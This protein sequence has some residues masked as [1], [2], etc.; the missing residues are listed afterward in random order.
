MFAKIF[1]NKIT[2]IIAAV[3][4]IGVATVGGYLAL[5]PQAENFSTVQAAV[6]DVQGSVT[7]SGSIDSD[8]DVSLSFQDSGTVA[9]VGVAVGDQVYKGETLAS[10]DNSDLEAQLQ[11]AKA[12]VQ[13]AQAN[14]ESLQNGAT[15]QTLA[16]YDQGTVTATAALSTTI[17]D[18]YL[19]S[20][21]AILN[22]TDTLF[23]NGTSPNPTIIIPV[24][25]SSLGLSI[26]SQR[27]DIGLRLAAWKSD[28]A[29]ASSSASLVVESSGD[30]SV[31][32]SFLD[33]LTTEVNRLTTSNSGLT[34]SQ[35]SADVAVVN[36][37]ESEANAALSEFNAA[38]NALGSANAQLDSVQA[39]STPE[40]IDAQTAAVSKAEASVAAF[41]S[42][43]T[44]GLIIAPFDGVVASVVPK[45]GEAFT[46]AAPAITLVSA[47]NY[48]IDVM[49]P[50]NQV[51]DIEVGDPASL[52]FDAYGSDLVATATVA[53]IDLAPTVT[54]GVSAYKTT[55]Y[56]NGSDPRIRAGMTANATILG[57][58]AQ[59][60]V[61]VPSSAI[62]SEN[63][64]D[65]VLKEDAK[66]SF[67]QSQV[68]TG[69]TGNGFTEILSGLS[70][71]ET[72]ANFGSE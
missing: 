9:S 29:S 38:V 61:A 47:G 6:M 70:A 11:G 18:S 53:S 5:R 7:A 64:Q 17:Q 24:D 72:V 45:V 60:V 32:K 71:G 31:I 1:E 44:D 62:I 46:A 52:A 34:Q 20:S 41:E 63:G 26:N 55:L 59:N 19:K 21:D 15:S 42:Q 49:I 13:A 33:I 14:L 2:L 30:L 37:A 12:D 57:S 28:I 67:A 68:Q 66:G 16:I 3:L 69:I 40:T 43:I 36:A 25:S 22:K 4:A 58:L 65:F 48:K 54:D 8:Q 23:Q 10:L 35:I 39:S 50:E 27:S 51:A 56:L